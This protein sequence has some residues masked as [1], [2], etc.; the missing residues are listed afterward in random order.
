MELR[1]WLNVAE[2]PGIGLLFLVPGND[3]TLRVNGR[4]QMTADVELLKAVAAN[5]KDPVAGL[6]VQVE[7]VYFHCGKALT[8]SRLWEPETKVER[9]CFLSLGRIAGIDPIEAEQSI[10]D[11]YRTKFW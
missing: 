5:G 11:G 2:N 7:K 1:R 3:E 9:S 8:R 4:A 6:L 10:E